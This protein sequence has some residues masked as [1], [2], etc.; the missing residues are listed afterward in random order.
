LKRVSN[1][2]RI[3][4]VACDMIRRELEMILP[5]FPQVTEVIWLE[6]ALHIY[7]KRMKDTIIQRINEVGEQVDAVFLG[8]GFCQSLK[9]IEAEV[10]VPVVLP[11]YDDCIAM[12]ITPER[13]AAEVKKEVGTWFMTPGWAEIGAQLVIKELKLE[14]ARK[15]GRDPM[16]MARRLFT[17]YRRGLYIDTG[18][19]ENEQY[20]A[21]A[22][23]F[24]RD[25]NLTLERTSASSDILRE[26]L[27]RCVSLAQ[28]MKERT[29]GLGMDEIDGAAVDL[30]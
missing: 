19:G 17:H 7:P 27:A 15:Y 4:V 16:E 18:V 22:E 2:V 25:F 6:S 23:Q 9:G 8:Y 12:L 30:H 29:N 24:C 28:E 13:Y 26:E 5:E 1:M 14:R 20:V 10:A 21:M 11:Q 3:G